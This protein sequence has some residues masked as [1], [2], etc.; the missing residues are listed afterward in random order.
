[1][2]PHLK[3]VFENIHQ[4]EFDSSNKIHAMFSAEKERISFV[5]FVDP[6]RKNVEDWMGEVERMMK[7]SI[8]NEIQRCILDYTTQS[9]VDWVRQHPGQCVLNGSQAHWTQ[10]VEEAIHT[11]SIGKYFD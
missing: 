1:V 9:R 7:L 11:A 3:K 4:I 5:K 8:R 10:E 2:Q 6:V